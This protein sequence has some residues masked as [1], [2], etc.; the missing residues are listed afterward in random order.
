[1]VRDDTKCGPIWPT[2]YHGSVV[3]FHD[4]DVLWIAR[5]TANRVVLGGPAAKIR[6]LIKVRVNQIP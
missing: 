4:C 1:M 2:E 5:L 6:I 3:P